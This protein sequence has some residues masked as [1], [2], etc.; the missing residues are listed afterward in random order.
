M[1]LAKLIPNPPNEL[2]TVCLDDVPKSSVRLLRYH[3]THLMSKLE[4]KTRR[5]PFPSPPMRQHKLHAL[6]LVDFITRGDNSQSI[7]LSLSIPTDLQNH[8]RWSDGNAGYR[9]NTFCFV[10]SILPLV[11]AINNLSHWRWLERHALK[12]QLIIQSERRCWFES[13]F[14]HFEPSSGTSRP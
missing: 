10:W 11:C 4:T 1:F 13:D 5:V 14:G 2:Y 7:D 3:L 12:R 8:T 9:I 6:T